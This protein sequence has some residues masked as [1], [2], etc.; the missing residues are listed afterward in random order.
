MHHVGDVVVY[1][2]H[3]VC[4]ITAEE[5]RLVDRKRIRYF[6]LEP[7]VATSA[8]FYIPAENPVALSKLRS[9]ISKEELDALLSSSEIRKNCWIEDENRRKQRYRE[10]IASGDRM[11]LLQMIHS[12]RAHKRAQEELGRKFHLC[13]ENFLRDAEKLLDAEFAFTLGIKPED[14]EEYILKAME[15]PAETTK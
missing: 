9:I 5:V 11:A 6:V 3:G 12:L 14:V 15:L 13:D 8:K 2:I 1:G 4:H 10:L 7:D